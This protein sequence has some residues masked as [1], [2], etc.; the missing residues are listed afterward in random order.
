[1]APEVL[2]GS[3]TKQADLWS[4]G[5]IAFMLLSSQMPFYG[6]KRRHI[7]EQIMVGKF[8]FKGRR[9]K[10]LSEQS[11][12]FVSDLLVLDPED[13]MTAD[14][15]IG[16]SWLNRRHG[17]TVRNPHEE[18]Y[19][20]ARG[21]IK[22]FANYSKLK[23]VALMVV[24]HKSTSEEIG[25]LRK[26]FQKY[27]TKRDGQLS[28]E[29]F[30]AAMEDAG[31]TD[32]DYRKLFDS[33]DMDGSGKIR[34]T[35]FLASTIEAHGAI[36]EQ[37]L[38]EAFDRIDADDSGYISKENLRELLGTELPQEEIDSII[39]EADLTKDGKIS[40]S[41]FLALWEDQHEQMRE[42]LIGEVQNLVSERS[43]VSELSEDTEGTDL[44]ARANFIETKL[45]SAEHGR[46]SVVEGD[47]AKA[48]FAA[49]PEEVGNGEVLMA[50]SSIDE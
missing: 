12:A 14:E 44:V 45:A 27:D 47:E 15:A 6:R 11:K 1:M 37:R 28:F 4:I 16:A 3:Y 26:V 34:Y 7:V 49:L 17:A 42:D 36:S 35:E 31:F 30:K 9:W 33:I 46:T 25:I 29:E 8:E 22:K 19:E 39:E 18:E 41:E 23:K 13:R 50:A 5:V 48:L 32:E 43:V 24:A 40:Y 21:S 10:R 20:S 2:K 38:A